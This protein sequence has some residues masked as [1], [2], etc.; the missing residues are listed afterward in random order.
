VRKNQKRKHGRWRNRSID[1]LYA[2]YDAVPDPSDISPGLQL[3]IARFELLLNEICESMQPLTRRTFKSSITHLNRDDDTFGSFE[4]RLNEAYQCF[5]IGAVTR[6][7]AAVSTGNITL[8]HHSHKLNH[9]NNRI[10]L[11]NVS[12]AL[13]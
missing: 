7:E 2:L 9:L 8:T 10:S 6:I 11:L 5:M 13:F 3:S 4:R 1:V 12:I